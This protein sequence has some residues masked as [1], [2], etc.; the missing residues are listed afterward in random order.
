MHY[1]QLEVG[2]DAD[3]FGSGHALF[4][5]PQRHQARQSEGLAERRE[6]R[7]RDGA[8]KEW[9]VKV[10]KEAQSET[11]AGRVLCASVYPTEISFLLPCVTIDGIW[12]FLYA[13]FEA[14]PESI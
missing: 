4:P 13:R 3:G 7:V 14:R 9:V 1:G 12:S 11:V 10:G 8:G 5:F 6:L 2:Q